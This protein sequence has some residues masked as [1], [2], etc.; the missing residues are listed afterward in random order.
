MEFY[1]VRPE[2]L[3]TEFAATDIVDPKTG[4]VILRAGTL[5]QPAALEKCV[6]AGITELAS[7][8]SSGAEASSCLRDTLAMDKCEDLE[9]AQIDIYKRLRPSSPPTAEISASF[10]D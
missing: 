6:A 9:S 2:T 10:F 5:L 8:F 1:E 4:E 3:E 7:I